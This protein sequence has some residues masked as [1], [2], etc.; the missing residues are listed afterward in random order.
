MKCKDCEHLKLHRPLAKPVGYYCF[1]ENIKR[2]MPDR[3]VS[4]VDKETK[5][6]KI[7][8]SPKWCPLRK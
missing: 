6:P 5:G 8:T 3:K 1:N 2:Q 7:K 4:T